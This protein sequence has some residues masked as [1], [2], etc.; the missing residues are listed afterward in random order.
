MLLT[1]LVKLMDIFVGSPKKNLLPLFQESILPVVIEVVLGR[2]VLILS[3]GEDGSVA[4]SQN[5]A[6][7]VLFDLHPSR[8]E[9]LVLNADTHQSFIKRPVTEAAEGEAIRGSIIM[10]LAPWF[11]VGRLNNRVAVWRE[12]TYSAQ[13][14]PVFI[15]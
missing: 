11:D 10:S 5:V 7:Q 1:D 8:N 6:G 13:S 2:P 15:K 9:D 4:Q 12:H 3:R 14:A